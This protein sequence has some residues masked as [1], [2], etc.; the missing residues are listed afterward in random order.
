MRERFVWPEKLRSNGMANS[1]QQPEDELRPS[2]EKMSTGLMGV[3]P[4]G[5]GNAIGHAAHEAER[6]G[7]TFFVGTDISRPTCLSRE[8]GF[9]FSPF[10]LVTHEGRILYNTGGDQSLVLN[11]LRNNPEKIVKIAIEWIKAYRRMYQEFPQIIMLYSSPYGGTG[12][13]LSHAVACA[14]RGLNER[15]VIIWAPTIG[16]VVFDKMKENAARSFTTGFNLAKER[17]LDG[18]RV[19]NVPRIATHTFE[20]IQWNNYNLLGWRE[21]FVNQAIFNNRVRKDDPFTVD[22]DDIVAIYKSNGVNTLVNIY[23]EVGEEELT[24]TNKRVSKQTEI[25]GFLHRAFERSSEGFILPQDKIEMGIGVVLPEDYIDDAEPAITEFINTLGSK[26]ID[27][28]RSISITDGRRGIIAGEIKVPLSEDF[29]YRIGE[30]EGLEEGVFQKIRD[31][32][33]SYR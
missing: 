7:E 14:L 18:I 2:W 4:G 9:V 19:L 6:E 17:V 11:E 29:Y 26:K 16:N 3:F 12:S 5:T 30:S 21:A 24:T 23:L 32:A 25:R 1:K 22:P 13:V 20:N 27:G 15:T 28:W 31:I 8:G 33:K 10:E